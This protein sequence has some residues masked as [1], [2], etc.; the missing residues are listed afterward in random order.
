MLYCEIV[1]VYDVGLQLSVSLS[2]LEVPFLEGTPK[3]SSALIHF[4]TGHYF[5]HI[6]V[7]DDRVMEVQTFISG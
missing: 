7:S 6:Q 3:I 4:R 5:C 2:A 1:K